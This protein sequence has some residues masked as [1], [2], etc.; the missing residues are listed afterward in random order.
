MRDF[1]RVHG[2]YS[3]QTHIC[4]NKNI[5]RKRWNWTH[6]D[7]FL[8][9]TLSYF[10]LCINVCLFLLISKI[11]I[12]LTSRFKVIDE[13]LVPR[14]NCTKMLSSCK[15]NNKTPSVQNWWDGRRDFFH[16]KLFACIST[17]RFYKSLSTLTVLVPQIYALNTGFVIY[18]YDFVRHLHI[19]N[20]ILHSQYGVCCKTPY[21]SK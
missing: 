14:K 9:F 11:N 4:I 12:I 19:L 16:C 18:Y 7:Y 2:I 6:V 17:D 10:Y 21:I 3:L 8:L 15:D 13:V 1:Q 20:I 5:I